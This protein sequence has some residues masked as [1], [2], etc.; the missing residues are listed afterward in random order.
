ME[1]RTFAS[2]FA[3]TPRPCLSLPDNEFG[4]CRDRPAPKRGIQPPHATDT[5]EEHDEALSIFHWAYRND[6]HKRRPDRVRGH[7]SHSALSS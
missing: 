1:L 7:T 2:T 6:L 3:L 5:A 4:R